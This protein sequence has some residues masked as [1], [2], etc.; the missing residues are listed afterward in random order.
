M[1]P[2]GEVTSAAKSAFTLKN[3]LYILLSVVGLF[4]IF[5]LFGLTD[6][7]LYPKDAFMAEAKKRGWVKA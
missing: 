4:L 7:L 6:W 2:V 1:N 3:M 5:N